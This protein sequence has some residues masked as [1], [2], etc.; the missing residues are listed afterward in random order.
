MLPEVLDID[1]KSENEVYEFLYEFFTEDFINNDT[2]V[3]GDIYVDPRSDFKTD[4]KEDVFWHITTREQEKRVKHNKTY[5]K[6]K[7]RLL[8]P[9]RAIR[10]RW[11][12]PIL[13]N[14]QDNNIRIFYRKE[15]KG[16]KPI[17]LYFW[18]HQNDF[19]VIVQKLGLSDCYLVTSFYITE[20]YKR[21]TYRS[22]YLKYQNKM[23]PQLHN[24]EWF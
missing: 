5:K 17:R 16:K 9:D 19:V 23:D 3:N 10:I 12:R 21:D 14:H 15:T 11:V 24:C 7:E 1:G 18:A 4:G 20:K 8:D 2:K 6:I 22:W 13:M